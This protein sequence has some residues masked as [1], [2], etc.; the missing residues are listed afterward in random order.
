MLRATVKSL[1]ARKLRLLLSAMAVVLGVSFVV[2]AF[3][4]TDSLGRTFT[5][6]FATVNEKVAVDVRGVEKAEGSAT[7]D[8]AGREVVPASLVEKVRAVDGVAEVQGN[9]VRADYNQVSVLGKDGKAL[10]TNGA[11]IIGGNWIDSPTLNQQ[12]IV[13]GRAPQ[14]P[15]EALFDPKLAEKAGKQVGD[16]AVVFTPAGQQ[17]MT[18]VGLVQYANGKDTL[19]GESY[20]Q[21]TTPVAQQL[22]LVPGYSDL[23]VAADSG[24]SQEQLRDRVAAVLPKTAEAVTGKQLAKEQ[25]TDI[26]DAIGFLSTFLL[27]F[28]AVAL[29]VGAFIIFNTFSILVAQRT[30]ELALMRALGA[31]RRQ[32]TRSVLFEALVVGGIASAIGL[33]AGIGVALG[34]QALFGAFGAGL[35]KATILIEPRTVIVAFA[36]GILVT[37]AAALL[38]ARRAAKVPP[39]AAMR[40]AATP[41]RSLVRQTIGG[42]VLAVGGTV[43][44]TLGLTGSPLWVLGLGAVLAFLGV[45]LLSPLVS[46]PVTGAL[47]SLL[48]RRLPGRLGRLNSQRNP[49]RTAATA[50]ALMIGLALVAAV[51]VLGASLKDSVRKTA[52]SA[53]GADFLLN[54]AAVGISQQAVDAVKPLPGLTEVTAF[55]SAR[56]VLAGDAGFPAAMPASAIGRTVSLDRVDGS[57]DLQPGVVLIDEDL[58]KNKSLSVGSTV[59]AQYPDGTKEELRVGG[60]YK[61][62]QLV[63]TYVLDASAGRHFEQELYV[64]ALIKMAPGA[65]AGQVR[66]ELEQA[67]TPYPNVQ[68]QDRSEFVGQITKQIDQ[69]IQFFTLLLAL[70]VLIAVLG[71]VNTLALSVLERTRELGL[72]RAVGMSRRQV[73]RMVRVESVLVAVFGGLLGLAVGAVLGV[74]LQRALVDQGVTE[75]TFPVGQLAVYLVLAAVAGV[76]AAW[77]P[78]R[79]ASRLNVLQAIAAE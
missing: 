74:A 66:A 67:I 30:R 21:F 17:E 1:L 28:A 25:A 39:I 37:A 51:G 50:A 58:A 60:T 18:L 34:L 10:S 42:A 33:G 56:V 64:A 57:V 52:D 41:D 62:N 9:V 4:L 49:R 47:G 24:V 77:L 12:R 3:V 68:L 73:K 15:G 44:I 6:L 13:A 20:V 22:L 38:P 19:G 31:S 32:V 53:L 11:P 46:R 78:A 8:G 70:S 69:L 59:P 75:L 23:V 14:G 61:T 79:R 55:R 43:A 65:D 48:S 2:G 5:D 72:L 54:P 27:V 26:Q 16:T 63:G 36:V 35:P 29:F 76:I 45:A 71:I 40:D 7:S